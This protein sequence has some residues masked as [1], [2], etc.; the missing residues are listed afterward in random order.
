MSNE[1]RIALI[2]FGQLGRLHAYAWRSIPLLYAPLAVRPRVTCVCDV[3]AERAQEG[4]EEAEAHHWSSDWE[5]VLADPTIDAVD[6][7]T[8]N[9]FHFDVVQAA[10]KAHKHV[11]C[12]KPLGLDLGQAVGLRNLALTSGVTH[13]IVSEYRYFPAL[14]RARE[15]VSRNALGQIYHFR[16][17]YLH[18]GYV[19]PDRPLEWRLQRSVTGGGALMDLGPHLLDLALMLAGPI[20]SVVASSATFITQRP[21]SHQSA[22]RVP[23]DVED[24]LVLLLRF[25]NGALGTCELS[26]VATGSED[27]L[28]FTVNG[29]RGALGFNLMDPNWLEF[30]DAT[31]APDMRGVTRI[32]TVQKYP[33]PAVSPPPKCA[34]GYSRAHIASQFAFLQAAVQG[35]PAEPD[36]RQGTAVQAVIH[37]AYESAASGRW[38][39]VPNAL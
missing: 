28:H 27:D 29:S 17:T 16:G 25:G 33:A 7:C 8:P 14:S 15:L 13:Q 20:E 2:G 23:V 9:A 19:D 22:E 3:D 4:A 11:Y 38:T 26:R 39:T 21:V 30:F 32:A 31:A 10:L 36:F 6:V 37:A 1:L 5:A 35:T 24:A 12:E 34:L 18:S